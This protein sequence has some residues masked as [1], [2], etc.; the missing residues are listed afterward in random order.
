[1][2]TQVENLLTATLSPNADYKTKKLI[3]AGELGEA[4]TTVLKTRRKSLTRQTL[5]FFA[6]I[7]VPVLLNLI[8]SILRIG[9]G[10][11]GRPDL[12]LEMFCFLALMQVPAIIE[13]KASLARLETVLAMWLLEDTESRNEAD[14]SLVQLLVQQV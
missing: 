6:M 2:A 10:S 7:I 9:Q 12:G 11:P 3:K 8:E 5:F 13:S 1:M 14:E 4:A